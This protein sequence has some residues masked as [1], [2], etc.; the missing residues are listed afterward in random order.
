M[1]NRET[2]QK[3]DQVTMLLIK[4]DAILKYQSLDL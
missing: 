2:I 4:L 3:Y 1:T